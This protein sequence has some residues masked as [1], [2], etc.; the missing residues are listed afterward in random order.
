V[1]DR[2]I[3]RGVATRLSPRLT[4][5]RRQFGHAEGTAQAIY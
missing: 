1:A 2:L 3:E 5:S 4:V